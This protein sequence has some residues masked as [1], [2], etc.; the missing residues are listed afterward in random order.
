V[1]AAVVGGVTYV[2]VAGQADDGVSVFSVAADGTLTNVDN[3]TDAGALQLD[4]AEGV[5][6]AVVAGVTYLFVVGL[7]RGPARAVGKRHRRRQPMA[8][9][10]GTVTRRRA[11]PIGNLRGAGSRG[12]IFRARR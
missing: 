12:T 8:L 9:R 3:V 5:G 2:F 1:T 7:I 11:S 4:G 6:T 10:C